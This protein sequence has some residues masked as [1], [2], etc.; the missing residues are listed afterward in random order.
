MKGI[1]DAGLFAFNTRDGL[2]FVQWPGGSSFAPWPDGVDVVSV[3]PAGHVLGHEG[4][5][6]GTTAVRYRT[7]DGAS[8]RLA[9]SGGTLST[10]RMNRAG[11]VVGRLFSGEISVFLFR[12]GR[13]VDLTNAVPGRRLIDAR[14]IT[15]SGAILGVF[16]NAGSSC[17]AYVVPGPPLAPRELT[18]LVSARTV[19]LQ[20]SGSAGATGYIVEAGSAPGLSDLSRASLGAG[21]TITVVAPPGRYYVRV[22]ARNA[23]GESEASNEVI[24]DVQ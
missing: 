10:G 2:P 6:D 14:Q 7:P 11:D 9:V 1:S 17:A 22:R 16:D 21:S 3:G 5:L 20:W 19:T 24:V 23:S 12:G 18:S 15:D 8:A 13:L 4:T